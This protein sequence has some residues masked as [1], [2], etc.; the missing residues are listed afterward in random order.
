MRELALLLCV[1]SV[2]CD[3]D[4]NP[5]APGADMAVAGVG[6]D[7]SGAAKM[8]T[9]MANIPLTFEPAGL[10]W[11]IDTK[12]LYIAN[13]GAQQI[14]KWDEDANTFEVYARL[15]PIAAANGGLGQLVKLQDGTWLVT[16]FGFGTAGA[17]LHVLKDLSS[18]T[19][20][21]LVLKRARIGLTVASDGT[22]FDGW[23]FQPAMGSGSG[24][25]NGTVSKL[26]LT[27]GETDVVTG[28]GK[29]VGLLAMGDQLYIS[30][31]Q[32]GVI[33]K[34]PLATP[35][36]TT[37][38]ATV[39]GADE[40]ALGASG[41][42]YAVTNTGAA[43]HVKAD[44]TTELVKDGYRALRGVAYDDG[45]KRLFVSEPDAA[46]PPDGGPSTAVLHVLPIQ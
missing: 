24:P 23:Y 42:F 28:I 32:A 39:A 31:Q 44:G 40:L 8:P 3:D 7:M 41:T 43:Y 11:D 5:T 14:V 6:Q 18:E 26:S 35:G 29:P 17:V 27:A 25:T 46:A 45:N 34:T 20:P 12:A 9:R 30:D 22:I 4:T 16:R 19:L 10:W 1:W 15:P 13:N 2:G 21:G 33:F 38:F 37:M 36:T